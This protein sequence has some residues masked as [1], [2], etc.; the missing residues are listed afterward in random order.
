MQNTPSMHACIAMQC[1]SANHHNFNVVLSEAKVKI[2]ASR[3][4]LQLVA[5]HLE[6]GLEIRPELINALIFQT[7]IALAEAS[8]AITNACCAGGGH[9]G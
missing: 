7:D 4:V 9:G 5:D 3:A 6:R 2:D 1:I 8:D